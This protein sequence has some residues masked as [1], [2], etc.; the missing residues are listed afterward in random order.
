MTAGEAPDGVC[1]SCC[2]DNHHQK[3]CTVRSRLYD[4]AHP[5][6]VAGVGRCLFPT[7][8]E[9]FTGEFRPPEVHDAR[10]SL[11]ALHEL[12]SHGDWIVLTGPYAYVDAVFRYCKRFERRLVARSE[13]AHIA[14]PAQRSAAFA[15]A[16]RHKI[17]HLLVAA[18]GDDLVNVQDPP[19]MTGFQEWLAEPPGDRLFIIPVRRLQRILT[20][21]RR[22]R[23]GIPLKFLDGRITILPHVYVPGDERVPAMFVEYAP[24]FEGARVL[25]MGTGTGIVALLAA[26]LG[27]ER[28]VATDVS[29]LAVENARLNAARLGYEGTVEVRGPSD[30]FDAVEGERFD[31][32]AFNAPWIQGEPR[33]PYDAALY[34][35]G[36]R[37]L[38]GF[39]EGAPRHLAS[40]GRILLQYSDISERMQK[41]ASMALPQGG[42]AAP[43]APPGHLA[44]AVAKNR[45]E[46][47]TSRSIARRSRVLG[48]RERV[49]L[50]EIRVL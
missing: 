16:R 9:V 28:V 5:V 7:E 32:I 31:V 36:F 23:E 4:D 26:K 6:D 42:T 22:S 41:T 44:E 1:C 37:V 21:M 18:R 50:F 40:G 2:R 43:A 49:H 39:L 46:I 8:F 35:P 29:P 15:E 38:D 25:D 12:L 33:T 11:K 45:L 17:H 47:V 10:E 3:D 48:A 30:L 19:D 14:D 34:D 13:C 27:A 24:L 20:D